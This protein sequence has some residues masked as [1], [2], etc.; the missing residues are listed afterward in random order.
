MTFLLECYF[1]DWRCCD[2]YILRELIGWLIFA[3][4][5]GMTER[6]KYV[7]K[8]K[9]ILFSSDWVWQMKVLCLLSALLEENI[10]LQELITSWCKGG[11]RL[12]PQKLVSANIPCCTA[13]H[14]DCERFLFIYSCVPSFLYSCRVSFM[15]SLYFLFIVFFLQ[16]SPDSVVHQVPASTAATQVRVIMRDMTGKNVWDYTLLHGS[17]YVEDD[18]NHYSGKILQ[19]F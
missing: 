11:K 1:A 10:S 18:H 16:N 5:L 7:F 15:T 12:N 17:L 2:G 9:C 13:L 4:Y 6:F 3:S 8:R 14:A 19:I